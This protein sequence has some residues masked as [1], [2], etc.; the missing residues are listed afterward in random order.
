MHLNKQH[1]L[2]LL[3]VTALS[4][5]TAASPTSAEE[6]VTLRCDQQATMADISLGIAR[7][8]LEAIRRNCPMLGEIIQKFA[9]QDLGEA[10]PAD[11]PVTHAREIATVAASIATGDL[12]EMRLNIQTARAKGATP[13]EFEE[14]LYLTAVN[15]GI[16]KAIE[17]TRAISDVLI[18]SDLNGCEQ[19]SAR[20][21]RSFSRQAA[22]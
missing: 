7:S 17:A 6:S 16:P 18:A 9:M 10:F 20:H 8:P 4:L 14:M 13:I 3:A 2:G 5:A 1:L 15:D 21:A 22:E 12:S 11:V 19:L